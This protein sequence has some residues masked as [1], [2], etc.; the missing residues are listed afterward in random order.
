[1]FHPAIGV[2]HMLTLAPDRGSWVD[3]A[4]TYRAVHF[5]TRPVFDP[6]VRA[7]DDPLARLNV[8]PTTH[9]SRKLGS[10]FTP[11]DL[12]K[13][14]HP[15]LKLASREIP[16]GLLGEARGV[17]HWLCVCMPQWRSAMAAALRGKRGGLTRRPRVVARA[18]LHTLG[19]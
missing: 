5:R 11:P 18:P 3:R 13:V 6:P 9:A 10:H 14:D 7:E 12:S 2:E 4:A 17:R 1:L 15:L 19:R 8:D 16:D